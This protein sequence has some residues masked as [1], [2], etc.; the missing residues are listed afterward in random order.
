MVSAS[1]KGR[2]HTCS[3]SQDTDLVLAGNKYVSSRHC[4]M[5][6]D[7]EGVVWL[8]DTR[9]D[10]TAAA[11]SRLLTLSHLYSTNGTLVNGA[12]VKKDKVS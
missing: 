4:T 6:L 11:T 2:G 8:Q 7:E 10:H 12:V 3:L 9:Q 5:Q 1:V